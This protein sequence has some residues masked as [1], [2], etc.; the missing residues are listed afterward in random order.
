[1]RSGS[2]LDYSLL[3]AAEI[4]PILTGEVSTPSPLNPLG[5]KG[6]GEGG[7]VGTLP[8]VA[9]AVADALGGR[10][11]DPPYTADQAVAGAAIGKRALPFA[12]AAPGDS[13]GRGALGRAR[14]AGSRRPRPLAGGQSLVPMLNFRLARPELLVDLNPLAE[15]G[16]MRS[17]RTATLRIGALTRQAALERSATIA[18]ALAAARPGGARS[19]A[20][21]AI[22]SRGTV[23]GS[24]AHADPRAE[25]PVA[26]LALRRPLHAAPRRAASAT[27]GC[28]RVVPRAD[29]DGARA[30]TSCCARSRSRR[31]RRAR[32]RR[33]CEYARTHGDFALAGAP[34]SCSSPASTRAV[35]LLG[36]AGPRPCA[37]PP[38]RRRCCAGADDAEVA[39]ALGGGRR[40][41]A[42]TTGAR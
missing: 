8:A 34:R 3:T 30:T 42:T 35:A 33:S 23:G 18:A 32:G 36:A 27:V 29:D 20:M 21:P 9:N 25:L 4:P 38:P 15:L 28:R 7:A 11:L 40:D 5:A 13:R 37:P 24:V 22:R 19:S 31:W 6:A 14:S 2:L 16:G 12:Y 1:M 17:P 41:R 39:G 10:H 26:L